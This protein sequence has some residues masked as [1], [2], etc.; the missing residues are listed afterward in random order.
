MC[1]IC[2]YSII[3]SVLLVANIFIA[4]TLFHCRQHIIIPFMTFGCMQSYK[5]ES[6]LGI[7][8]RPGLDEACLMS[9]HVVLLMSYD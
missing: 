3:Y 7:A 9:V 2:L 5:L 1:Y 4:I 6:E 8:R